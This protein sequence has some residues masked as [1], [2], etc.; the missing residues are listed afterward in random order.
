M[1]RGRRLRIPT[2]SRFDESLTRRCPGLLIRF[3]P[4]QSV[5]FVVRQNK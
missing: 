2:V 4:E 1:G 3:A 5:D